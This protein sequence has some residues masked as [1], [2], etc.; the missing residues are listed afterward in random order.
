MFLWY[1]LGIVRGHWEIRSK[2]LV[3]RERNHQS[4]YALCHTSVAQVAR[5]HN[6]NNNNKYNCTLILSIGMFKQN[7]SNLRL[8][9]KE[10]PQAMYFDTCR[11]H[12]EVQTKQLISNLRLCE[13]EN[14]Q[15]MSYFCNIGKT[16]ESCWKYLHLYFSIS[17][18]AHHRQ[19]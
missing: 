9:E 19:S 17:I 5:R 18:H 4:E 10:N 2:H 16:Y 15:A 7:S 8:H 6:N 14:P 12:R 13:K 3:R 1:S 11:K